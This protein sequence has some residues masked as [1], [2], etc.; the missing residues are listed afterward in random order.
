MQ[1][2][3]S[4]KWRLRLRI[5][6]L[7]LAAALPIYFHWKQMGQTLP[8]RSELSSVEANAFRRDVGESWIEFHD[9]QGHRYQTK[10]L[11]PNELGEIRTAIE[12]GVPVRL[13]YGRWDSP[14]P[15]SKISTVYSIELG[16]RILIPYEAT[17]Q[18]Q[19][20]QRESRVPVMLVTV[21]L[22]GGAMVWGMKRGAW[23]KS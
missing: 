11:A 10:Y 7:V 19:A 17:A 16:D 13:L 4:G 12:R 6:F 21:L 23:A 2:S 18:A 15:S 9:P 1:S 14:F 22:V 3:P 20:K 5:T 8:A